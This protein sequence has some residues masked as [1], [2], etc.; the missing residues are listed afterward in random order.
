[1][2][3]VAA[4][5]KSWN[6][7]GHNIGLAIGVAAVAISIG[8]VGNLLDTSEPI[9]AH[10]EST[11]SKPTKAD[12]AATQ[13][14][15]N[16]EPGSPP[17]ATAVASVASA[18]AAPSNTPAVL[19]ASETSPPQQDTHVQQPLA[20]N[21]PPA[22]APKEPDTSLTIPLPFTDEAIELSGVGRLSKQ[23]LEN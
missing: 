17:S 10:D 18:P 22:P 5:L 8:V 6:I 4:F 12:V 20:P 9:K 3:K 13:S 21:T 1:M 15:T 11:V 7:T 2:S 16:T 23:L 19:S 14:P